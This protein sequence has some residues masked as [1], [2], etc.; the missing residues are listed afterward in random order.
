MKCVQVNNQ[1]YWN[2]TN[3]N[4]KKPEDYTTSFVIYLKNKIK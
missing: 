4:N 3:N 2:C 1:S